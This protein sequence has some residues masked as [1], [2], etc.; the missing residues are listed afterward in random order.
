MRS[1]DRQLQ[2]SRQEAHRVLHISIQ[3]SRK[4]LCKAKDKGILG[5]EVWLPFKEHWNYLS[6]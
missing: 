2:A 6:I 3:I 1:G 4:K 5:Y